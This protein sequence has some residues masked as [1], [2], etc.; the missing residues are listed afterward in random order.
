MRKET[1]RKL[2]ASR[3]GI[4]LWF[5]FQI[6]SFLI[7]TRGELV[8]IERS[9]HSFHL[10]IRRE[11]Y[12]PSRLRR[13]TVQIETRIIQISGQTV[14]TSGCKKGIYSKLAAA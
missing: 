9:G 4:S 12:P 1:L 8:A 11:M 10:K 5:R 6:E 14:Q 7:F 3:L 2:A 13:A